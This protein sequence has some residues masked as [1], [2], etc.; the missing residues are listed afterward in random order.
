MK[1]IFGLSV[2]VKIPPRWS[3]I[4]SLIPF[5]IVIGLYVFVSYNRH[6]ANPDDKIVPTVSQITNAVLKAATPDWTTKNHE[7]M[8]LKDTLASLKR[9]ALGLL[10]GA[11]FAISVGIVL[12]SFPVMEAIFHRFILYFTKIPPLALVPIIFIISGIDER[13]K[14]LII[15]VGIFSLALDVYMRVKKDLSQEQLTKALTL[16]A[17]TP[18]VVWHVILPQIIPAALQGVRL[19]LP[20]AWLFLISSESLPTTSGLGY[21]IFVAGRHMSM[22]LIIPY[23]IWIALLAFAADWL[24]ALWIRRR[25]PWYEGAKN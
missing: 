12:G 9:F 22:D 2:H 7:I 13:T 25:Y 18:E 17:S 5:I 1:R 23:V 21:R 20:T 15:I 10:M 4:L 8:L 11:S 14:V 19:N 3:L 16:G 6:Q 24:V